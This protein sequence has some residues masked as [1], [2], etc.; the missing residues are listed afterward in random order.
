[1]AENQRPHSDPDLEPTPTDEG[2]MHIGAGEQ[3]GGNQRVY[4]DLLDE[5]GRLSD[6]V[7]E[8][9]RTAWSSPERHRMEEDVRKTMNSM[10]QNVEQSL[11]Q[12]GESQAAKDLRTQTKDVAE[13]INERMQ[14]SDTVKDLTA[15]LA[16]GL[17]SLGDKL[18]EW[19]DEMAE[20][21]AQS[22]AQSPGESHAPTST[23][24]AAVQFPPDESQDI[25]IE[26]G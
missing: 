17:R 20:R 13:D 23:D 12:A 14:R 10:A 22:S 11:K 2:L 25:P 26:R 6:K 21:S 15:G 3:A 9:V 8:V 4:Q 7:V 1:M 19:S 24:S 5:L 16:Q 18:D